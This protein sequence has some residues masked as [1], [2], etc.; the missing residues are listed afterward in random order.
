MEAR[1][2][3]SPSERGDG[4]GEAFGGFVP[5]PARREAGDGARLQEVERAPFVGPFDVLWEAKMGFSL[6]RQCGDLRRLRG[7]DGGS[8]LLRGRQVDG[9]GPG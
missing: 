1:F 2:A 6:T 9:T 8:G 3:E 7:F 4:V 5:R